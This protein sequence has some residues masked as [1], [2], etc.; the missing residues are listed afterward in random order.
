MLL[1][2]DIGGTKCAVVLGKQNDHDIAICSKRVLL[3]DKPV[4][5]MI[6]AL[7]TCAENLLAEEHLPINQIEGIGIS[8]GGPLNSKGGIIVAPP[9][10]P[11]WMNIPIVSLA[12]GRFGIKAFLQN[13][14]N[15][16]AVAE[17]KYGAG[18]GYE[19][20]IFLTFGTGMGAG[21]IL[22]N[23]LYSGT[24]DLAGEV[25]HL[26][27]SETGPVGFGKSGSFEGWCSGGGIAQIAQYKVR[28]KDSG[29][30]ESK[31]L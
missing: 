27:L 5:E 24:T 3:T 23:Q 15:A 19:N 16:C 12:E 17:W 18:K 7:F 14:A 2:F 26:R 9:N 25:G 28:G 4:Y 1:G 13:D 22:N 11:G 30:R 10:L 20:I 8:C 21:L 31:L 6:E 29:W